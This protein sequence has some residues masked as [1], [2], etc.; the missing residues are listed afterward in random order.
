MLKRVCC[1][2]LAALLVL[3]FASCA[4]DGGAP[5]N[6]TADES[7]QAVSGS[8][9]LSEYKIVYADGYKDAALS[10]YE[11]LAQKDSAFSA[12]RYKASRCAAVPDEGACEILIGD[13]DRALSATAQSLRKTYND[14][15]ICPVGN[16]IAIYATNEQRI[17]DALEYFISQIGEMDGGLA[18][19]N[20]A[21][22]IYLGSY[23]G[24]KLSGATIGAT[25]IGEYSIVYSAS[26]ED[27]EKS[28]ALDLADMI[29]ELCGA[30]LA[31]RD[32]STAPSGKE[33][34]LGKTNRASS[35]ELQGGETA[36]EGKSYM[37]KTAGED[38][39]LAGFTPKAC[40]YLCAA[41]RKMLEDNGSVAADCNII[42]DKM[43]D[44]SG[45]KIAVFGNSQI[46]YGNLVNK[47]EHACCDSK[48]KWGTNNGYLSRIAALDGRSVEVY[49]FTHGG[50]TIQYGYQCM[51]DNL[52]KKDESFFADIDYIIFSQAGTYTFNNLCS[53]I[54][55]M[56]REKF[57]NAQF[58]YLN[59]YHYATFVQTMKEV[60]KMP[61]YGV[62]VLDWGNLTRDLIK[63][64][65][66]AET[67]TSVNDFSFVLDDGDTHPNNLSGYIMTVMTYCAL[68]GRSATEFNTDFLLENGYKP[69]FSLD[70]ISNKYNTATNFRSILDSPE[71]I[72]AIN[73]IID[74]YNSKN[75]C[76]PTAQ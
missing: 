21:N 2:I 16:K 18:Y 59:G 35:S 4:G 13:T 10:L 61:R 55:P 26:A 64:G 36:L 54:F 65:S 12:G 69:F 25:P 29:G 3:P 7:I 46:Y 38:L 19:K 68:T 50:K 51:L 52:G 45:A 5:A 57:P 49:N 72:A 53:E 9:A 20:A 8:I 41:L 75:G 17:S 62:T 6:T 30:M 67:A 70:E 58:F 48:S 71:D 11:T 43:V 44:I 60:G 1:I 15:V 31:V 74:E 56:F 47:D 37:I 24:Y 39:V 27:F 14:F 63:A 34:L 28:C 33:I 22:G 40:Q 32:D 66:I 76:G 23:D 42:S 73:R